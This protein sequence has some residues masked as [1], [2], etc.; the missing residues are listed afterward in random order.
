MAVSEVGRLLAE[1]I[2]S[3]GLTQQ[4]A[5]DLISEGLSSRYVRL[6]LKG[7][8]SGDRYERQVRELVER[9]E[10]VPAPQRRTKSG[11]LAKVRAKGG[12]SAHPGQRTGPRPTLTSKG[13]VYTPAPDNKSIRDAVRKAAQGRR[14][15][16]VTVK[17]KRG[18]Y[19]TLYQ[20]GGIYGSSLL[21]RVGN[22]GLTVLVAD[23][24]YAGYQIEE[25]DIAEIVVASI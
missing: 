22:D 20:K 9:G 6:I 25:G 4:E 7:T 10:T 8:R 1:L 12:G 19:A 21:R 11:K 18:R 14:H 5:A 13:K 15:V 2:A 3:K 16:T 17:T 24:H 23:L